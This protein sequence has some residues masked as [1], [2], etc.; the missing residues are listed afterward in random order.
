MQNTYQEKTDKLDA[1]NSSEKGKLEGGIKFKI[2][3]GDLHVLCKCMAKSKGKQRYI[4]SS[5]IINANESK[6]QT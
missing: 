5:K 6:N 1:H 4:K 3:I 2:K